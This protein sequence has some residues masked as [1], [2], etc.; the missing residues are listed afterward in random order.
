MFKLQQFSTDIV[1]L[2]GKFAICITSFAT[3]HSFATHSVQLRYKWLMM[4]VFDDGC[5]WWW[6][7]F[8]M[9]AKWEIGKN[10]HVV[11]TVYSSH[12]NTTNY[13]HNVQLGVGKECWVA[14]LFFAKCKFFSEL[15]NIYAR[16]KS[17]WYNK[18]HPPYH[19]HLFLNA[20]TYRYR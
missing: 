1:Q 18:L 2:R 8:M 14:K 3:Q 7:L 6:S 17:R 4:V 11:E 10:N 13:N 12:L 9:I 15:Y 5:F 19:Q 16:C 20:S